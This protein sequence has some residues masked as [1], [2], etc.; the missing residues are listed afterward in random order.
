M[1]KIVLNGIEVEQDNIEKHD[2]FKG[3]IYFNEK[4]KGI[5]ESKNPYLKVHEPLNKLAEEIAEKRE[6]SE[7]FIEN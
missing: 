3:P 1:K 2:L 6:L 4:N 7:E 5:Y